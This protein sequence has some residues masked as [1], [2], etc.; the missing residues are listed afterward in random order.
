VSADQKEATDK[1]V[2]EVK[3]A[4]KDKAKEAT[5]DATEIPKKKP[6]KSG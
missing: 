4:D 6:V 1:A 5:P 2:E 3:K